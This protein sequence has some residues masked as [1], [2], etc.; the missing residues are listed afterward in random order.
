MNTLPDLLIGGG[1][2]RGGGVSGQPEKTMSSPP[3]S[4]VRNFW[5]LIVGGTPKLLQPRVTRVTHPVY[6]VEE[7]EGIILVGK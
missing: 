2:N 6:Y 4:E 5:T 7:I 3:P 1:A